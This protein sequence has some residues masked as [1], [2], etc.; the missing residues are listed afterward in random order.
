MFRLSVTCCQQTGG[1]CFYDNRDNWIAVANLFHSSTMPCNFYD[2]KD[3][4]DN[5]KN[6]RNG[7][8]HEVTCNRDNKIYVVNLSTIR[9]LSAC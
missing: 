9:Q 2:N 1:R 5:W 8:C 6:G 3:N 4:N 7:L